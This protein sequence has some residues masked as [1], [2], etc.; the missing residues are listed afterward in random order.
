MGTERVKS[1]GHAEEMYRPKIEGRNTAPLP[2]AA[3][4]STVPS[5]RTSLLRR[6]VGYQLPNTSLASTDRAADAEMVGL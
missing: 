3:K 5:L 2:E 6:S 1:Q 4:T